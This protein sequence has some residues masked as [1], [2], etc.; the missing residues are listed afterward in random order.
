MAIFSRLG[1]WVLGL[2]GGAGAW[3]STEAR[4]A[5]ESPAATMLAAAALLGATYL[6]IRRMKR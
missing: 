4:R 5:S 2:L 1:L 6:I 3:M